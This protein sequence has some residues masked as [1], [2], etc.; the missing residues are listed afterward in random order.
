LPNRAKK[1]GDLFMDITLGIFESAVSG[2][3]KGR[4]GE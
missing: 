3:D 2:P 1:N 4:Y